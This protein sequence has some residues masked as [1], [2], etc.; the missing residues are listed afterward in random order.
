MKKSLDRGF[1]PEMD[2]RDKAFV[3]AL[4]I[5]ALEPRARKR[6]NLILGFVLVL[7]CGV[8]GAGFMSRAAGLGPG[9][10][11]PPVAAT[12]IT[13]SGEIVPVAPAPSSDSTPGDPAAVAPTPHPRTPIGITLDLPIS[14]WEKSHGNEFTITISNRSGLE[15][16]M[17]PCPTYRMYIAGTDVTAAPLRRL[18]CSAIGPV[19]S[20]GQSMTLQMIYE[21]AA[22][23][24]IGPQ[25]FVWTWVSPDDYQATETT[26]LFLSP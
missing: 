18:N 26:K 15:M 17:D 25:V 8:I 11:E 20:M 19:L 7:V 10:T 2:D 16:S 12:P 3:E 14:H 13:W 9:T 24:P 4:T 1:D 6:R 22:D 21:P 5:E 23:D